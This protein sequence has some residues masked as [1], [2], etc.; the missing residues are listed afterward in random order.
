VAYDP[1]SMRSNRKETE[2]LRHVE[3]QARL[4]RGKSW[5]DFMEEWSQLKPPEDALAWF[6]SWPDGAVVTPVF[7]P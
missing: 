3:R 7:R 4:A 6:G 5:D 2:E 1:D